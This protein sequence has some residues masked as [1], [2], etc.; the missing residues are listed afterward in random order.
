MLP[1]LNASGASLSCAMPE[2]RSCLLLLEALQ[3]AGWV[4]EGK[5]IFAPRRTMWL[6]VAAPYEGDLGDMLERMRGRLERVSRF[7]VESGG[8]GDTNDAAA[9]TAGLVEVLAAVVASQQIE[10]PV[11]ASAAWMRSRRI[12]F[13]ENHEVFAKTVSEAFL[14]QHVVDIIP[15]V[16]SALAAAR[17]RP[18]D[19]A[20]VDYDLED[21][22]GDEFVRR[23][24]ARGSTLAVIGVS[25]RD[26]GNDVLLSAGAD[27]V[28]RKSDFSSIGGVVEELV[29][30][31]QRPG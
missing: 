7:S 14:A 17:D 9:D 16:A 28:C 29:A 15:S 12:L 6:L 8:E 30:R 18:Y 20:L 24:R 26:E 10:A 5:F 27:L 31:R 22:K 21:E 3:E 1:P 23:L 4:V 25:A 19:V 11:P 13:L 2:E